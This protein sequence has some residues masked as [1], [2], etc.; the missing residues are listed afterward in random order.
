MK[1]GQIELG[2]DESLGNQSIG[3]REHL[4][5]P[6]IFNGNIYG[7]WLSLSQQKQCIEG[8]Q[9]SGEIQ[10]PTGARSQNRILGRFIDLLDLRTAIAITRGTYG[11]IGSNGCHRMSKP[12]AAKTCP[13]YQVAV[14]YAS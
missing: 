7:F 11:I 4:Q 2:L 12:I 8:I 14:S 9:I 13:S 1:M 3:L 10:I 6:P 5:E